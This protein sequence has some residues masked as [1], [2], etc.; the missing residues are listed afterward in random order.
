MKF[1]KS[2]LNWLTA[3]FLV[4]G[5]T[6][7]IDSLYLTF[8][9]YLDSPLGCV[10]LAGCDAVTK[11]E[12]AEIFSIP[13]ALLGAIYYLAIV[14]LTTAY[15][16]TNKNNFFIIASWLTFAGFIAS[17]WFLYLQFFVIKAICFYCVISAT[18]STLL[19]ISGIIVL[20]Y[21]N[22]G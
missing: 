16:K 6:G 18:T 2:T 9:Y 10:I 13:V 11:S 21:Q 4:F 14:S 7:F 15:I 12:H 17:L 5:L 1:S 8:K 19:F 20:K 3:L 22:N